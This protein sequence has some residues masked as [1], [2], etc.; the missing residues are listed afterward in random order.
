MKKEKIMTNQGQKE[1]ELVLDG[2]TAKLHII[3]SVLEMLFIRMFENENVSLYAVPEYIQANAGV[4]KWIKIEHKGG[5]FFTITAK[6]QKPEG[7][8]L[9]IKTA[10]G[11]HGFEL[12]LVPKVWFRLQRQVWYLGHGTPAENVEKA[13]EIAN[14]LSNLLDPDEEED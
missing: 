10:K 4:A 8:V 6:L 5:G 11:V 3:I 2:N 1:T 13:E 14:D 9:S 7:E 12:K